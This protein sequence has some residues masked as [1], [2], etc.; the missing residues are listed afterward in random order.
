MWKRK[1][2]ALIAAVGP[3]GAQT[4]PREVG[5][6]LW[7]PSLAPRSQA[8]HWFQP[9]NTL[10]WAGLAEG[11]R[12]R[13]GLPSHR[14]CPGQTPSPAWFP[15]TITTDHIVPASAQKPARNTEPHLG[16]LFAWGTPIGV[17]GRER[18][19]EPARPPSPPSLGCTGKCHLPACASQSKELGWAAPLVLGAGT[20]NHTMEV[21]RALRVHPLGAVTF[22][23]GPGNNPLQ[24]LL[25]F[26]QQGDVLPVSDLLQGS[27]LQ[28]AIK[29][30]NS[31]GAP[32]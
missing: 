9:P 24:G 25:L 12:G 1:L 8:G 2:S 3:T 16:S 6:G 21:L 10:D 22:P 18:N 29:H 31:P 11:E 23:Q 19:G 20:P 14:H 7:V 15:S 27:P 26:Y 13:E 5:K 17:C 30:K 32:I 28:P 4:I